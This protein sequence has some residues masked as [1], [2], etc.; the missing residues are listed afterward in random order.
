MKRGIYMSIS[1]VYQGTESSNHRL[2][3]TEDRALL[4]V[5]ISPRYGH[6]KYLTFCTRNEK[7]LVIPLVS[8][9][10]NVTIQ[11]GADVDGYASTTEVSANDTVQQSVHARIWFTFRFAVEK[12]SG[13]NTP[14]RR[15]F[16]MRF[17]RD[18]GSYAV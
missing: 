1:L 16:Q 15:V 12:V 4:M 18:C 9:I 10:K 17:C 11:Y 13:Y 7:E 3:A 5:L 6:T 8:V 14:S 2:A